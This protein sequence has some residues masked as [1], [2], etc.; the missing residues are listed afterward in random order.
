[1]AI[2]RRVPRQPS[3]SSPRPRILLVG[4]DGFPPAA[5]NAS[6]TPVLWA[7]G[8]AGGRAAD[9]GC[10]DLPST[11]YPGFASLLTGRHGGRPS[12]LPGGSRGHGVRTTAHDGAAVPGWA[13]HRSVRAQTVLHA[14][15]AAGLQTGAVLGDH[16]LHGVLDLGRLTRWPRAGRVPGGTRLDAHGYPTNGAVRGPLLTALVEPG[17]DLLFAQLNEVDSLG[18]DLGPDAPT[19]AEARRTTDALLGDAFELLRPE[20]DRT[21]VI[22]VSDHGMDRRIPGAS[23]DIARTEGAGVWLDGWIGDGGAAWI[24][25]R[26]GNDRDTVGDAIAAL[27]GVIAVEAR[28][29]RKLLAL[30][31]PGRAFLGSRHSGGVHGSISTSRT[32]AVVG[33]GH[34]A[35]D[36]MGL[37]ITHRPPHLADWA[38]AIAAVLGIP[39]YGSHGLPVL[40][41]GADRPG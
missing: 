2:R 7:L 36:L 34:E 39:L 3:A 27:D 9:G 28:G 32:L 21:I 12:A 38:P 23:I 26:D 18:H 20:W 6:D 14:A 40:L 11:T 4:L 16:K 19:T 25:V 5:V 33:G 29:T 1:M 31:G 22:V 35:A 24:R 41:G 8:G 17:W 10:A 15:D 30:A 37:V 13:G